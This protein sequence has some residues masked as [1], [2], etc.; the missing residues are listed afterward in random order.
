MLHYREMTKSPIATSVEATT[1]L[2]SRAMAA[3]LNFGSAVALA[4]A[5]MVLPAVAELVSFKAIENSVAPAAQVSSAEL[6][7][8][9]L[10][11]AAPTLSTFAIGEP[12]APR[13]AVAVVGEEPTLIAPVVEMPGT[14]NVPDRIPCSC[15]PPSIIGASSIPFRT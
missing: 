2:P 6:P 10:F 13:I 14:F 8:A 9:L 3:A 15:P 5:K 11:F 12:A 7:A 1:A 4:A